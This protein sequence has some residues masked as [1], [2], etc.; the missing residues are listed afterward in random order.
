MLNISLDISSHTS[1]ERPTK[2]L[3]YLTSL[4][5]AFICIRVVAKGDVRY[6]FL[7][8]NI[9]LA[10]TPFW[11]AHLAEIT[12]NKALKAGLLCVWLLFFPNSPYIITDLLHLRNYQQN[13]AWFDTILIFMFALTGLVLGLFALKK[14]HK[15]IEFYV[16]NAF[17]WLS[18]GFICFISGFGIYL[19]RYCRLNSWDL[20]QNPFWLIARVL[21]Q[22]ENPLSYQVTC[23]FGVVLLS[24]YGIFHYFGAPNEKQIA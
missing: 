8:W 1:L 17:S 7:V 23:L 4:C 15:I 11:L 10:W 5:M 2:G 9:F 12:N 3:I 14:V 16:G 18:I 21:R 13:I 20:F 19:G 6:V 22:F 24:L